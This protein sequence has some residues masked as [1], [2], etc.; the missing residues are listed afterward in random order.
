MIY[1]NLK[2][3]KLYNLHYKKGNFIAWMHGKNILFSKMGDAIV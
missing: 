2:A 1:G 3:M